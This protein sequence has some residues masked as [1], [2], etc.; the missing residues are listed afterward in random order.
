MCGSL[1]KITWPDS[2]LSG[3]SASYSRIDNL[4][5]TQIGLGLT[6]YPLANQ[7][8]Y[9]DNLIIRQKES[10][11][12]R[13]L[14]KQRLGFRLSNQIW[15]EGWYAT[16]AMRYFNEQNAFIVFNSPNIIDLRYGGGFTY[17]IKKST[18]YLHVI[19][20]QK[21]EYSTETSFSYLDFI[22]GLNIKL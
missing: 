15:L 17:I 16:G 20:E 5:Q 1:H 4:N 22:I 8:L 6:I 3:T 18:L 13:S 19:K 10:E 14:F 11:I 2:V 7:N 9:I 12:W 21:E